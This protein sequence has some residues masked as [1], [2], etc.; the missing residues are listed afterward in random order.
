[1]TDLH[2]YVG[3]VCSICGHRDEELIK[4]EGGL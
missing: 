4:N 1:M 3:G 2:E